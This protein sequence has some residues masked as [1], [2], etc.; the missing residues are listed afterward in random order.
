VPLFLKYFRFLFVISKQF[1]RL[2][3]LQ[4]V[5]KFF[6]VFFAQFFVDKNKIIVVHFFEIYHILK[7]LKYFVV[8][9]CASLMSI[10]N[11]SSKGCPKIEAG[12]KIFITRV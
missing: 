4:K 3:F 1:F 12:E 7:S 9:I 5:T 11:L 8:K 10:N 2:A 6:V